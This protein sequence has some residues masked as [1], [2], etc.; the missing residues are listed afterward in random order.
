MP[1][2]SVEANIKAVRRDLR[3]LSDRD[4]SAAINRATNR[5]LTTLRVAASKKVR[6]S[7]NIKARGLN[8][9]LVIRRARR[10]SS[11]ARLRVAATPSPLTRFIGTRQTKRGVTVRIKKG[12]A[13]VRLKHAFIAKLKSGRVSVF[14]R[15]GGKGSKRLPIEQLQS[16]APVQLLGDTRVLDELGDVVVKRFAKVLDQELRFRLG[17]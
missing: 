9:D 17:K 12:G 15:Q 1:T 13:R 7:L 14:E 4:G 10:G 3:K 16:T 8:K 5:A 11:S 2:I 6:E